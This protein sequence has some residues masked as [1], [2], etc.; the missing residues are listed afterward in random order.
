MHSMKKYQIA[1]INIAKARDAIDSNTMKGF[2][3]RLDEINALA[4]K[5]SGFVWR[6]QTDE[7]DATSIQ[8]FDDPMLI[9]NLSVWEDIESLKR[10]VY[11]SIHIE[12]VRDRDA[13]FSKI[14]EAH[15]VLWWVPAG[16]IPSI[17]EGKDRLQYLEDNGPTEKAFTFAKSFALPHH[18]ATL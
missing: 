2:V 13:W 7:G 11:Q 15:Q 8:A 4:D 17:E 14:L 10:F 16:H 1:Q 12:L 6:L 9:V 5:S 3:D 18:D